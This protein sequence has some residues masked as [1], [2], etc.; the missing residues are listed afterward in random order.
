MTP[1]NEK[2]KD[3][4]QLVAENMVADYLG[5]RDVGSNHFKARKE[6]L[7]RS[8][9]G[10]AAIRIFE[11]RVAID[12][13]E[14]VIRMLQNSFSWHPASDMPDGLLILKRMQFHINS[15]RHN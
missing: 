9:A 7:R 1:N 11:R 15:E 14:W 5:W 6:T 8:L 13:A 12:D 2:I 10:T 3:W 4:A